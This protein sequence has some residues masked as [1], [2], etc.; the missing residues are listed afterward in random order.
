MSYIIKTIGQGSPHVG[1]VVCMHGDEI[2]GQM[3]VDELSKLESVNGSL[4]LIIANPP[5][6]AVNQRFVDTDLNRC[7]PGKVD[8]LVEER[9]ARDLLEVL[10]QLDYVIDLH[11]TNSD[12]DALAIVVDI[13]KD[14]KELLQKVPIKKVAFIPPEVFSGSLIGECRAGVSIEFGPDKSGS[15][16]DLVYKTTKDILVNLGT[17]TGKRQELRDRVLYEVFARYTVDDDF[18]ADPSLSEFSAI[19]EGQ[20]IGCCNDQD[21]LAEYSFHPLFLGKG[22]YGGT[23]SLASKRKN[24]IL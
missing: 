11:T 7:F 12:I 6:M 1:L 24:I 9:L 15:N 10:P 16:F 2:V 23:M 17:L 18:E 5:A 22:K 13:S 20:V 14:S 8:G 3:V 4:S 19:E 21:V